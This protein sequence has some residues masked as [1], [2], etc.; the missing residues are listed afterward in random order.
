[1]IWFVY[2]YFKKKI[3]KQ[4]TRREIDRVRESLEREPPLGLLAKP[5]ARQGASAGPGVG[6]ASSDSTRR[7]A[8]GWDIGE[9][10]GFKQDPAV[11][12]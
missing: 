10:T 12:N 5:R 1:M 8:L 11:L 4:T 2:I 9:A 3:A 6:L 7:P